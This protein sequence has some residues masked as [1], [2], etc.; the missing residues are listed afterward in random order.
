MPNKR[1]LLAEDE[2]L[3]RLLVKDDLE[4][5]GFEVLEAGDGLD[6]IALL[7]QPG[8]VD[9]IVTNITMPSADGIAIAQAARA[10]V[11]DIPI[12]FISATPQRLMSPRTP[13]PH[14]IMAKPFDTANLVELVRTLLQP[15]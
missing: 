5:N 14:H 9:L 1:I 12:I 7:D 6:A 2:Y 8:S 10:R 15:Q 13:V 4:E 3:V 11:Q